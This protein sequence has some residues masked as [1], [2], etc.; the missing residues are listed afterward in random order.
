MFDV[1]SLYEISRQFGDILCVQ[2]RDPFFNSQKVVSVEYELKSP[3]VELII[4]DLVHGGGTDLD[5]DGSA[6]LHEGCVHVIFDLVM[7]MGWE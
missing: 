5:F 2:I 7:R 3:F 4:F 1:F 6:V